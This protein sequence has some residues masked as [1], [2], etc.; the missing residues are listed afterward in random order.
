MLTHYIDNGL[1]VKI[2]ATSITTIAQYV[3]MQGKRNSCS[4]MF[5]LWLNNANAMS[6]GYISEN[7]ILDHLSM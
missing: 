1:H 2:T 5:Y 4:A 6:I 3:R 7:L